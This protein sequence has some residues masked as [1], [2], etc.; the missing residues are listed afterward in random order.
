MSSSTIAI[1]IVLLCCYSILSSG[2][3]SGNTTRGNRTKSL[4]EENLPPRGSPR[5]PPKT[6]EGFPFVTESSLPVYLPEVFRVL[7][8]SSR[9]PSGFLSEALGPA[10]SHRVAPQSFSKLL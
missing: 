2:E 10:A 1:F 4:R 7:R 8:R 5:G 9:R 3:R 6:S